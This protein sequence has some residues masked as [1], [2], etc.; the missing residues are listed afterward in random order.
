[1]LIFQ[2]N[3]PSSKPLSVYRGKAVLIIQCKSG[4]LARAFTQG[5]WELEAE[6]GPSCLVDL[7][8]ASAV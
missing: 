5:T 4:V 1:M 6:G 7:R 8:P 3:Y 2:N